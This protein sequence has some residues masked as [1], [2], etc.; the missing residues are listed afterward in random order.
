MYLTQS[1]YLT[2]VFNDTPTT[3]PK[4]G[5]TVRRKKQLKQ[6]GLT[7]TLAVVEH[8]RA[9]ER[10]YRRERLGYA[11]IAREL[12]KLIGRKYTAP[13]VY[14]LCQQLKIEGLAG[15]TGRK[16]AGEEA[17]QNGTAVRA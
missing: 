11:G 4:G 7:A 16:P 2:K 10:R 9:N 17:E 14:R 13:S 8:I 5:Q 3:L 12:S 1:I 6:L 15:K